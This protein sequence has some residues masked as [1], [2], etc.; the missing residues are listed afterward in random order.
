MSSCKLTCQWRQRSDQCAV[1]KLSV[2]SAFSSPATFSSHPSVMQKH[3]ESIGLEE[4]LTCDH[5]AGRKVSAEQIHVQRRAGEDELQRGDALKDI[6]QLGEQE[7]RQSA[8]LVH[9]ILW[10]QSRGLEPSAAEGPAA[11]PRRHHSSYAHT[12]A[13]VEPPLSDCCFGKARTELPQ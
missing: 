4:G 1:C 3:T 7:V 9:L 11:R 6:T 2:I 5:R 8:A 10:R 13:L 12:L